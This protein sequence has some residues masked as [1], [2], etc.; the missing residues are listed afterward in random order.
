MVNKWTQEEIDILQKNYLFKTDEEISHIL[1]THSPI[2][3]ATKRK[4]LHLLREKKKFFFNDVVEEFKKTPY[5][6]ISK[7][8]DYKDTG[9]NSIKYI[10]P[11]H[12]E[13]GI[14]TISL[15][16]L[17]NGRGCYYCGREKTINSR[18]ANPQRTEETCKKI[19]REK[20]FEYQYWRR[21]NGVIFI[22]YICQKHPEAGIQKMRKG[23]MLRDN[24]MGCP[25][26]FDTKRFKFSKGEKQIEKVLTDLNIRYLPQYTF[27]DCKD[28]C[29]LPFDYFL[30]DENKCIEYDGQHHY[31]PVQFNGISYD[32]ATQNFLITNSHDE[33][34]NKY[35]KNNNIDLLRIPYYDFK[36]IETLITNFLEIKLIINN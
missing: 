35:C 10:C 6:L 23:N 22:Y 33:I 18:L 3:V 20:G 8:E 17:K 12:K 32:E 30:P 16:H 4:R 29:R 34:K 24:V 28:K 7:E 21:E 13:K 2:S 36:K 9:T 5:I 14:Q 25:Y 31:Y 11:F 27:E 1:K 19:C 15:S 26:C